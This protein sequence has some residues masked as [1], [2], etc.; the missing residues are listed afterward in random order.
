MK[1]GKQLFLI[2]G[3]ATIIPM[4]VLWFWLDHA[5]YQQKVAEVQERHLLIA[6]NLRSAL[7]RYHTDVVTGF[8]V[9][10]SNLS[11]SNPI[12]N[13][14]K[15][16]KNLH[17][18][19][20]CIA[21]FETGVVTNSAGPVTAPCPKVAPA[22]RFK[23]L[24]SLIKGR[25]NQTVFSPVLNGPDN[26]PLIYVVKKIRNKLA[27]GALTTNYF[28]DLGKAISFGT[29]GHAAIVDQQGN[30]LAHPKENWIKEHKNI[31][32]ISAVKRM[33]KGD[34]GVETFYSP[35][36]KAD[37]IAGIA[38]TKNG[39]WSVMVPQPISELKASAR[40]TTSSLYPIIV[41][42]IIAAGLT[43]TFVAN[44]VLIPLK[45]VMA[46]ADAMVKGKD[47]EV[48]VGPEW[49]VPKEFQDLQ[50]RFNIMAKSV[51]RYQR[52][53]RL[54][55]QKAKQQAKGNV[56]YLANLAHE[57]KTPLNSILGF[58]SVLK[59]AKPGALPARDQ[60]E[61][62]GHIEKSAGHMLGFVNDLLDLNRLDMGAR[63]LDE[64]EIFLIEP[65]RF[66]EATVRKSLA[67]KNITLEIECENR[68]LKIRVDERSINQIMINLVSN[69]VRY[70]FDNSVVRVVA[71]EQ[72]DGA[73]KIS[74]H[75][76]GIGIPQE[77]LET[78]M[79]PFKRSS[80]PQI[81]EIHGTG[82]GLS[83]V[84]KLAALHQIDFTIESEHGFNTT[85]TLIIP[86]ERVVAATL[87]NAAA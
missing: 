48:S 30:I 68:D 76:N 38:G 85:V 29:K 71:E 51:A 57:L 55:R 15:I 31:S 32:K 74:V 5:M 54:D 49:R 3:I 80:D 22:K 45:H 72:K 35:A 46:G 47:V 19:H 27:I 2:F 9:V 40:K 23:F 6:K 58:S 56:E 25:G 11:V 44:M 59:Q 87:R 60:N 1:L 53:Q 79:L 21:D 26:Q 65:I 14:K 69:A 63:K 4:A 33:L 20:F 36:L 66:C 84:K 10:A 50:E 7:D 18:R 67:E 13:T 77:D 16:I 61:F 64:Q 42:F 82:L 70:S 34:I 43:A 24:K 52:Q 86:K 73:I 12:S 62:L 17:F 37:M 39:L 75:D 83:I 78:I 28:V 8:E 41:L 81:A